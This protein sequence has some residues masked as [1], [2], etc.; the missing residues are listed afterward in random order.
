MDGSRVAAPVPPVLDPPTGRR[1]VVFVAAFF[2]LWAGAWLV[3]RA[4]AGWLGTDDSLANLA[5]WASA[6]VLMWVVFPAFYWGGRSALTRA[7]LARLAAF[8][9]LRRETLGRGLRVGL[10][11]TLIWVALLVLV[12]APRGLALTH[13]TLVSLYTFLLTPVLEEVMFRGYIQ[14]ALIARGIPFWPVNFIGAGL[15]LLAHCVGWAF[16]GVLG[17]NMHSIYPASI[18]LVSLVLGLVR[19]RSNSLLASIL[20]H[21]GNNAFYSILKF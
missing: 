2:A 1:I 18:V 9:G 16:Q 19:H 12:A 6:K 17:A 10:V 13:L 14:S 20:L 15:F 4:L 3:S 11:A 21:A 7:G 8:I 5:Y